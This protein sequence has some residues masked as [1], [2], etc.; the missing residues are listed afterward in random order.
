MLLSFVNKFNIPREVMNE[1]TAQK[2]TKLIKQENKMIQE[3]V[4]EENK[5]ENEGSTNEIQK[6]VEEAKELINMIKN[7]HKLS[8]RDLKR[9]NSKAKINI[10]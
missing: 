9:F 4:D 10:N 6:T 7:S 3:E 8:R 5:D 1:S 2:F